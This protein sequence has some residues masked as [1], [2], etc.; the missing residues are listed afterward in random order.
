MTHRG[1]RVSATIVTSGSV[2]QRG[3]SRSRVL[4]LSAASLVL[5]LGLFAQPV[6]ARAT[7]M[8]MTP[9]VGRPTSTVT[10]NS[11]STSTPGAWGDNTYGELG[12]GTLGGTRNTPVQ[13]NGLSGV[14]AMAAGWYHSVAL[15]SDGTVWAWGSNLDGQLGNGTTT[16][17]STTPVQVSG[18]SGVTAIAASFR[19][20]LAL[21]SDGTMWG[22]GDNTYGDLGDGTTFTRNSPVQVSGL[23][24]VTA[25]A[26]GLWHSLAV[27][28]DGSAWAWG[29]NLSGGVGSSTTTNPCH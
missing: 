22:W 3:L 23:S 13:V 26:A 20:S 19:H 25:I 4:T 16:L 29:D 14:T 17:D 7:S 2:F 21:K 28:S 24:G 18:L 10:V 12:D 9:N 15:K 11:T 27:E 8:T 1:H 5:A 6:A